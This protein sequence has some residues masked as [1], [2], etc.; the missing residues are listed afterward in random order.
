MAKILS[1]IFLFGFQI[2]IHAQLYNFRNFT[3]D[4]GLTNS[5][6][7]A[8]CEDHNGNLWIG[9]L[10]GGLL[11]YDGYNFISFTEEKGLTNNFIRALMIDNKGLLWIGTEKGICTYNGLEFSYIDSIN[12]PGNTTISAIIQD[13]NNNYWF[14]TNQNGIYKLDSNIFSHYNTENGLP[15]NSIHCLYQAPDSTIWFGT[16]KGAGVYKNNSFSKITKQDGLSSNIIRGICTDYEGNTWFA[17]YS[18]G[19]C[20]FNG[21]SIQKFSTADGISNRRVY[22]VFND[23]HGNIWFG[24]NRGIT[25]FNGETFSVYTE[26]NGLASNIVVDIFEDSSGGMWFGTSGGGICMLDSERFIHYPENDKLGKRVFSL[27]QAINGNMI[28]GSSEG[29]IT[30]FDG[31]EYSHIK[32]IRGFTNSKVQALYYA[33][34][35]SLWIGTTDDGV[36]EFKRSGFHKYTN[37]NGLASNSI[38]GFATDTAGNTWVSTL[39]SGLCLKFPEQ[40]TFLV[41]NDSNGIG[42]NR[43]YCIKAD[44]HG[45]IWA[46]TENGGLN[47]VTLSTTPDTTIIVSTYT[48]ENG[49][50]SNTIKSVIIDSLNNIFL[51]TPGGG[52][53]IITNTNIITLNKS[54]GLSSNNIYSLVIDNDSN[55]WIGTER[56]LDKVVF[57]NNFSVKEIKHFNRSDGF[58]GIDNYR[59]ASCIDND[60]NI[61]FGT[62]NG[63]VKYIPGADYTKNTLPKT[64]L[65]NIKLFFKDISETEFAD[66]LSAN[67][68]P[69]NLILPY[70]KNN[71]TF[72]FLSIH[73]SSPQKVKYRWKLEGMDENWTPPLEK[74]EVTYS[75]LPPGSY[76]FRVTSGL[77]QRVWNEEVINYSFT[78]L[79]PVWQETWFQLSGIML[80][81]II[82]GGIV[83]NR[84]KRI[85]VKNRN[86]QEKLEMEKNLIELEQEAA[87]LQMNPHF[88][89]NSLN[90]IQGFIATNEPFQAKRYLA[91]FARLMRLILE[92]AREEFIPLQ[93]EIDIL[94]N[95]LELERLRTNEKFDFNISL[96]DS[97]DSENVEIPPMMIQP[98]V[99]NAIVHG[100]L[101]KKDK[102]HISISFTTHNSLLICEITD[103]G[104]GRENAAKIKTRKPSKHKSTGISVTMKRLEQL[105]ILSGEEAGV[106]IE[107]LYTDDSPGGTKVVITI[108]FESY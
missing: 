3:Y 88:I 44:N 74:R 32:G 59:N 5:E 50:S 85:K 64:H 22:T 69:S 18:H 55:L 82:I 52:V 25:K 29:G 93:N 101:S 84:I 6:I 61:W 49:L 2:T 23:T 107:D 38:S 60:G 19:V 75:N 39:D 31:N 98:F 72:E 4:D 62:I 95:Y 13:Y 54:N 63:V 57:N 17:T 103:N 92:N 99:E 26:D 10:G 35:S 45:N 8:I 15:D 7:Y 90:S 30:V 21:D 91:K 104:I 12:G 20:K 51:G 73:L 9:T 71:L 80:I 53:N 83:Y 40:D 76:T 41:F 78:I 46:G 79:P 48:M 27:I 70:N 33:P 89:F 94:D 105:K 100:I 16:N 81:V 96:N 42:S 67:S 77:E 28:F 1:L 106:T 66:T 86:I 24:T 34:D 37:K 97:I 47:K 102:G 43:I 14:G 36:F 65:T 58:K 87:R 11:R 108:P 56:G 68:I